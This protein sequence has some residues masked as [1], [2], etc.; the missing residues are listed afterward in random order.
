MGW[1]AGIAIL[2]AAATEGNENYVV[3]NTIYCKNLTNTASTSAYTLNGICL[4]GDGVNASYN[5][6][7]NNIVYY[8][9]LNTSSTNSCQMFLDHS[10]STVANNTIT[11]NLFYYNGSNEDFRIGRTS[12]PDP[13]YESLSWCE[14]DGN[15]NGLNGNVME[16]NIIAAPGFSGGTHLVSDLPTGFGATWKPNDDGLSITFTSNAKDAGYTAGSP[17]NV[18]ILGTSR[19]SGS[20]DIGAY[21]YYSILDFSASTTVRFE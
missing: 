17:F 12:P 9:R 1:P 18:D 2:E 13:H 14:T 20:Y 16:N 10:S 3:N 5:I 19:A 6:I 15:W 8:V 11:N 4:R 21:E 7:R